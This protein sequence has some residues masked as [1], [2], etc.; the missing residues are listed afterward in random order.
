MK[1][2][3]R[4]Y[5]PPTSVCSTISTL[6]CLEAGKLYLGKGKP[7]TSEAGFPLSQHGL[8]PRPR[9]LRFFSHSTFWVSRTCALLSLRVFG[10]RAHAHCFPGAFSGFSRVRIAFPAR[11]RA[12]RACARLPWRV[13]GLCACAH[14]FPS[15][16]SSFSYMRTASLACFWALRVCAW[17]SKARFWVSRAGILANQGKNHKKGGFSWQKLKN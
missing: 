14:G 9:T 6:S 1:I 10:L 4:S 2:A 8:G 7:S 17:L 11:F 15:A 13:F 5:P 12:F 16:F 3:I